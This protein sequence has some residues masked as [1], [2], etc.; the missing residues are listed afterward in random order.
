[1]RCQLW[2][3][4]V[5]HRGEHK[6][7]VGEFAFQFKVDRKEDI[8]GKQK[9]LVAQFYVTLQ[10]DVE[11]WLDDRRKPRRAWS[12]DSRGTS[13][14][15]MS[16]AT[17][18]R[19]PE[20]LPAAAQVSITQIFLEFLII[21]ATNFGGVVPYLRGSLVTRRRWIDDKTFVEM[22]SLSQSL[23]GLRMANVSGMTTA[24]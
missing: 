20:V 6:S 21:G 12:T 13:P 10:G 23:P 16:D 9:K 4:I 2:Y 19:P 24:V 8:A 14:K 11:N 7:L 18:N 17:A 15:A 3:L 22:L 1:M 5:A